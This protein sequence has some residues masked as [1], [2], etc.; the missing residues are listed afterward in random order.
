L[1]DAFEKFV[2]LEQELLELLQKRVEQDRQMLVAVG[3]RSWT[4]RRTALR[5]PHPA[6]SPGGLFPT[7]R[8]SEADAV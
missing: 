3:G 2:R 1:R 5:F 8:A 7:P 4:G 6:E